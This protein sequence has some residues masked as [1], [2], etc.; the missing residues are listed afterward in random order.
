[1]T[2]LNALKASSTHRVIVFGPPKTGKTELVG[3]LA[4]KFN[5][6]WFDLENGHETLFKLKPAWQERIEVIQ[7]PDTKI[8]PIAAETML[9]VI[10]GAA[11]EICDKHAKASCFLCKKDKLPT[12]T[13]CLN[14]LGPDWILVVDSLTQLA[15]SVMNHITKTQSD[16][17]KIEWDDYS[18][19]GAIMAKFLSQVQQARYNVVC[20]THEAE[21]EMEDG[22]KKIVPVSGTTNFSRNTAKYFDHVVYCEVKNKKHAFG[23][24]TTY[25]NNLLTGSRTDVA[26]ETDSVPSLLRIFQSPVMIEKSPGDIAVER[27]AALVAQV[28]KEIEKKVEAM[29]AAVNPAQIMSEKLLALKSAI[30]GKQA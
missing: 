23:S 29:E 11:V 3:R 2:K 18:K 17:Y 19:Q 26:L 30:K 5:L 27:N 20:I 21:V 15:S 25:G 4:E 6:L 9:K 22:R 24:S 13:V 10:T 7:L 16:E 1:M 14:E 28:D 12:T 8:Y